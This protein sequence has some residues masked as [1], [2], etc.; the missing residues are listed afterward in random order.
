MTK[1]KIL[2]EKYQGSL[3]YLS[4]HPMYENRIA[5]IQNRSSVQINPMKNSTDDYIYI[6]NILSVSIVKDI[7]K[8]IRSITSKDKYSQHKLALLYYKRS[9]YKNAYDV[10]SPIYKT[11]PN[12]LYIS[13]VYVNVLVGQGKIDEALEALNRTK[14]YLSIKYR[15]ISIYC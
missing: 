4:T 15:Y 3:E 12:N 10:I 9:D 14:K 5:G 6:K 1:W 7:N 13:L 2:Q 11:N 8:N